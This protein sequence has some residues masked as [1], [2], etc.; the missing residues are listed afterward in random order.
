MLFFGLGMAVRSVRSSYGGQPVSSND[1]R[2]MQ[3]SLANSEFFIIANIT[4]K[5]MPMAPVAAVDF[6]A[7]IV[8]YNSFTVIG[9]SSES[10]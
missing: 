5:L 1:Y 4:S 9:A 7:F 10:R 2:H 8:V 3:S 6:I